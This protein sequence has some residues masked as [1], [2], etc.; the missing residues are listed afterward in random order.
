MTARACMTRGPPKRR[1]DNDAHPQTSHEALAQGVE[2]ATRVH[3]ASLP[4]A[5]HAHKL[6][7]PP[8]SVVVRGDFLH[9]PPP[10]VVHYLHPKSWHMGVVKAPVCNSLLVGLCVINENPQ[11]IEKP[12]MCQQLQG[13]GIRA[14]PD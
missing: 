8:L 14:D 4:A 13:R 6:L 2:N 7:L 5:L 10:Y 9:I 3:D 12:R 1:K 11:G